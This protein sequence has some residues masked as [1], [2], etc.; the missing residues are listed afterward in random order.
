MDQLTAEVYDCGYDNKSAL[1]SFVNQKK[2]IK[3]FKVFHI[4]I[5]TTKRINFY[6]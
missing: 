1:I 2:N 5:Q 3:K 4:F 6:F